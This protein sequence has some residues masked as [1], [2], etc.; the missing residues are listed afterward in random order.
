MPTYIMPRVPQQGAGGLLHSTHSHTESEQA[1][2]ESACSIPFLS[3]PLLHIST[4]HARAVH[5]V[6]H[7]SRVSRVSTCHD[8]HVVVSR[9]TDTVTE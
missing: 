8:P 3:P 6:T 5:T 7:A 4:E 1:R 9:D 2:R